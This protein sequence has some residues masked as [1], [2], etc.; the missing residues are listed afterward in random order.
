M[1]KHIHGVQT[2]GPLPTGEE[3][4][5]R[6]AFGRP[7][8]TRRFF[9]P[10]H[11]SARQKGSL[12]ALTGMDGRRDIEAFIAYF[13]WLC[14]SRDAQMRWAAHSAIAGRGQSERPAII[15]RKRFQIYCWRLMEARRARDAWQS[16]RDHN[17]CP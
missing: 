9:A 8:P 2:K 1:E 15:D 16:L 14:A 5:L 4:L 7:D 10:P 17:F 11:R 3:A 6:R 12:P 13:K